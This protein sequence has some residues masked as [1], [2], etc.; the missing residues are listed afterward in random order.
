MTPK[1]FNMKSGSGGAAISVRVNPRSP[2]NEI[3]GVLDDGTIKVRLTAA[4]VDGKANQALIEFIA[5]VLGVKTSQVDIVAGQT[6]KDK[7]ITITGLNPE[8]V[9]QRILA[10]VK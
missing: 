10:Q 8:E 2:K 4:P 5:K 6:G 9:Q 1:T 7:L 3:S